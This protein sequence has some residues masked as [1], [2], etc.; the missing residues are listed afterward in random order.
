MPGFQ[1]GGCGFESRRQYDIGGVTQWQSSRPLTCWPWVRVPPP[2]SSIRFRPGPLF[3]G[4][5]K[6]GARPGL[7]CPVC[8]VR[9]P[10]RLLWGSRFER[11]PAPFDAAEVEVGRDTGL[12]RQRK[13]VQVPSAAF[14]PRCE[15]AQAHSR[16]SQ[17]LVPEAQMDEHRPS[18]PMV[19]GFKSLRARHNCLSSSQIPAVWCSAT[20][21][22]N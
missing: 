4:V 12:S 21:E 19:D 20:V 16:H 3:S 14:S 1:S 11:V 9:L 2:P 7:I 10:G 15:V 8:W 5:A 17:F 6:P 18:K 22:S 13:R